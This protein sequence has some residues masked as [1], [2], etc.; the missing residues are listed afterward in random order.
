MANKRSSQVFLIIAHPG[1]HRDGGVLQA[2]VL[3]S[4]TV[5][6]AEDRPRD[7]PS[8]GGEQSPVAG[9]LGPEFQNKVMHT[10]LGML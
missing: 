1:R 4:R 3:S 5:M 6:K 10:A 9:A 8:P 7:Q 2:S